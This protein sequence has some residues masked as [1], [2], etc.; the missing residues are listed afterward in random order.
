MV[1]HC[2]LLSQLLRPQAGQT[3]PELFDPLSAFLECIFMA[4]SLSNGVAEAVL[5]LKY[6]RDHN[7]A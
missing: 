6:R 2:Q 1:V 3:E 4:L 5:T 7:A